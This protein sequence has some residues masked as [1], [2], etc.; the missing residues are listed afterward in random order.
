[1]HSRWHTWGS[2]CPVPACRLPG[3]SSQGLLQ[4]Y[5]QGGCVP[6]LQKVV[7]DRVL[8]AAP[9]PCAC[10]SPCTRMT[11]PCTLLRA[12][13]RH[14]TGMCTPASAS[15]QVGSGGRSMPLPEPLLHT[16]SLVQVC[17]TSQPCCVCDDATGQDAQPLTVILGAP[18][19]LP[20][21]HNMFPCYLRHLQ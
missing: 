15:H 14:S 7:A 16:T 19:H 10:H 3:I 5:T 20:H 11:S 1:M 4:A 8:V 21:P 12:L 9:P 18:P 2:Q 13:G 6:H 17:S